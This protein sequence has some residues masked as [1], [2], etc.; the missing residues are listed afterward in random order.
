MI[1]IS[2]ETI[3]KI[4]FIEENIIKERK[5]KYMNK[6]IVSREVNISIATKTS[7]LY[8]RENIQKTKGLF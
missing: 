6:K 7:N 4:I 1:C 2:Y 5:Y 3:Y 8:L